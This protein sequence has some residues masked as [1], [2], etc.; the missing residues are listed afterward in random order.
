M[1]DHG[2]A[3]NAGLLL[4]HRSFDVDFDVDARS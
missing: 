2:N 1:R 3:T 4:R